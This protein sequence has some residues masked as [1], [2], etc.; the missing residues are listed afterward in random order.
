[1]ESDKKKAIHVKGIEFDTWKAIKN[2]AMDR[3]ITANDLWLK[4]IQSGA[5]RLK[6]VK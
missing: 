4:V 6:I 1:M 2:A 3:G 5:K